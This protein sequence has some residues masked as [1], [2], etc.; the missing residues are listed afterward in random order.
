[1]SRISVNRK[2]VK[3]KGLLGIRA[4]L[5]LLALI[6]VG[7]LMLDRV[8]SLE[9]IRAKQI[10]LTANEFSQ[11]AAHTAEAQREVI[12]S[13]QAV[14]KSAAYIHASA[15]KIGRSCAV[16]RA[17]LQVDLPWLR[18][19]SVVAASR[20]N[21]RS[22]SRGFGGLDLSDRHYFRNALQQLDLD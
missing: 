10:A 18:S 7:P 20:K 21:Q 13:V 5:V 9:S 17:S 3:L 12:A 19:L 1:M 14:L 11:L 4:R 16:I 15:A 6:L 2:K 8:R 22:T